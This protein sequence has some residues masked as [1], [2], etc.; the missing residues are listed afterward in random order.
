LIR[1][2]VAPGQVATMGFLNDGYD[3]PEDAEA[4]ENAG[5]A[6]SD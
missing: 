2:T 6:E 3:E 5:E 4:E 1:P